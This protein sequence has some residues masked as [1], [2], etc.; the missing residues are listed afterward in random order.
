M[1]GPL[2]VSQSFSMI[3]CCTLEPNVCSPPDLLPLCIGRVFIIWLGI[4][5]ALTLRGGNRLPKIERSVLP[6]QANAME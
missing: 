4:W 5:H 3:L 1:Q 6:L 2:C